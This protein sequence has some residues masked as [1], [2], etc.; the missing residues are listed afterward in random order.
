[1][2][3]KNTLFFIIILAF[4]ALNY[5]FYKIAIYKFPDY[6]D[7]LG[8]INIKNLHFF[9]GRVIDNLIQNNNY[10]FTHGYHGNNVDY[11]LGRLPFIPIFLTLIIKFVSSN[12]LLILVLK[13]LFLFLITYCIFFKFFDNKKLLLFSFILFVY[14]PHNIFTS[15]SLIPEE[16]YISYLLLALFVLI[17]KTNRPIDV[18]LIS[19]IMM[20][21]FFTKASMLYLCYSIVFYLFFKLQKKFNI[22]YSL[23]PLIFIVFSYLAWASFGYYKTNKIISPLSIS[24]MSGSTL[25]VSSNNKF[26]NYYHLQTPDILESEMWKKHEKNLYK[27]K[28]LKNEFEINDYFVDASINYILNNKIDFA[29]TSIKKL[30]VIFTNIKKDAQVVGSNDYNS[31]RFSNF[32]NKIAL[33]LSI[34][35]IIRNFIR[36]KTD[37]LDILF[38]IIFLSFL[39]PY[40]IGWAYTRHI[41]PIYIISHFFLLFKFYKLKSNSHK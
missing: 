16:G 38:I 9:F 14:N 21:I 40:M 39:F 24:T 4:V 22:F 7:I 10:I 20:M 26:K 25:I 37:D 23:L 19:I 18:V 28:K 1:M 17:Y 31:I 11:V 12:Y 27:D 3:K 2:L 15:L 6:I 30:H 8:N 32:P 29:K 5:I 36:R 34:F 13:N 41:V 35:I 33:I